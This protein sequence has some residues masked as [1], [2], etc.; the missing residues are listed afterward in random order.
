MSLR[1]HLGWHQGEDFKICLP[2]LVACT[3]LACHLC[4]HFCYQVTCFCACLH[5]NQYSPRSQGAQNLVTEPPGQIRR[6]LTA[7]LPFIGLFFLHGKDK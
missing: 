4:H 6:E 3:L 1:H 2:S 7:Y 5:Y